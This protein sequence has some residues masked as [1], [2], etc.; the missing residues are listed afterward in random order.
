M[1]KRHLLG[2]LLG[3]AGAL[4]GIIGHFILFQKWYIVG[5]N[6]PSAEPGCEILL[7]TIH[8]L[9]A[10]LGLLG[11]VLFLV[12]AY[13]FLT[14][15]NWAF[16]LSVV[17][18]VL[19]LLGSW[20]VNVPFMA[21]GLPPVYFPLFWPYLLLYFLLVRLVGGVSWPRTLLALLAGMAYITCWMNGV[22]STSRI[23]TIGA[24][25]F[26][27][28]QKLHWVATVGWAVATVGIVLGPRE[29]VRVVGLVAGTAE[30][31]VGIPLAIETGGALG[32][33]SLFALA[34]IICLALVVIF[35]W[36][37]LWDRVTRSGAE[38][39]WAANT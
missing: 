7:K 9:M 24:P 30:L 16:L 2:A 18:I 22:A 23:I 35:A 15:R 8:P 29:W 11:S 31:V 32:R 26:S 39:P 25:L 20:F 27:L 34:P 37:R 21:A 13:G 10:D 14:R 28:V 3:I 6:T 36:P 38:A 17:G 12:S 5:M 33:F 19:A 1:N 4:L